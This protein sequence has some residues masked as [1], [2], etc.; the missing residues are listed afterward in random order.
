[1][2][3]WNEEN[4]LEKMM[5]LLEKKQ[6]APG[7]CPD[8]EM[9]CAA[10]DGAAPQPIREAI[11]T[12]AARCPSCADLL[13]RLGQFSPAYAMPGLER[14]WRQTEKRLDSR[15]T[16]FLGAP[17]G[18]PRW[19]K[20]GWMLVP[21]AAA[22]TLVL[23]LPKAPTKPH[24]APVAGSPVLPPSS[25][26]QDKPAPGVANLS[27]S[28]ERTDLPPAPAKITTEP[29]APTP[30]DT[31][32]VPA[33][34]PEPTDAPAPESDTPSE[35][36]PVH[37][38][39][40]GFAPVVNT[41]GGQA[42]QPAQ[43]PPPPPPSPAAVRINAGTRVW[44]LLQSTSPETGGGFTFKGMVL[45]PVTQDGAVLLD[46][47]TRVVGTGKVSQGRTTIRIA[48]FVWH[49]M[50]Y[51][52]RGA[53]LAVHAPGPGSGPAVQFNAGQVLETWLASPSTY[54]KVPGGSPPQG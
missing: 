9:L 3:G 50:R 24:L 42:A 6:G 41:A 21:I 7:A 54:E 52:L 13:R 34:A 23:V 36:A 28:K 49:G 47:E 31:A 15:M 51:R 26:I 19:W 32:A 16:E 4:F 39:S 5:P 40:R 22:A 8:A 20:T 18:R 30:V 25:M 38:L 53:P 10:A 44:I 35:P 46:R 17:V 14:E 2:S 48:E 43:A 45:L 37:S 33:A 1:M 12:H 29:P 11:E 27:A